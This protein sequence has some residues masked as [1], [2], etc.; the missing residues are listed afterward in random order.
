MGA[1]KS[2]R[3]DSRRNPF[4]KTMKLNNGRRVKR[5]ACLNPRYSHTE[6]VRAKNGRRVCLPVYTINEGC[7]R[8]RVTVDYAAGGNHG[9]YE[10]VPAKVLVVS[11]SLGKNERRAVGHHE[12]VEYVG[13]RYGHKSYPAAHKVANKSEAAYRARRGHHPPPDYVG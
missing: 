2:T 7:L 9:A 3:K 13:M 5:P 11:S 12:M 6:C 1:S 8:D 10:W 4:P